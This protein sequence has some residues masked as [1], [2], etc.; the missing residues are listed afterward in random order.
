MQ[1]SQIRNFCYN[2]AARRRSSSLGSDAMRL[3]LK[4][5]LRLGG[6]QWDPSAEGAGLAP[7]L[8]HSSGVGVTRLSTQEPPGVP[9]IARLVSRWEPPQ[10][11][12]SAWALLGACPPS[13][14]RIPNC[15]GSE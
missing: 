7:R 11:R 5:E 8:F 1:I 2:E 6:F 15:S 12:S 10:F 9:E 13:H 14:G 3:R 4:P